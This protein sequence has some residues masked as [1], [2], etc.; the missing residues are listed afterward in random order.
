MKSNIFIKI[1]LLLATLSIL[2]ACDDFLDRE[3]SN[4]SSHGFYKSEAAVED[5]ASGVYNRLMFNIGFNIPFNISF[6]HWT[7]MAVE[8][9]E[10]TTIGAGGGLTPDN[11][12]ISSWWGG[13]YAIIG[14]ANAVLSGAEP[15]LDQLQSEGKSMQYLAEIRV[16]RA[17]AYYNLISLWGAVPFFT[18][19]VTTA[20]YNPERT[21]PG[22]I[23]DFI[24][25][26]LNTIA[27]EMPWIAEQRGRVDRSVAYGLVARAAL[28]GGSLDYNG[29][30]KEYFKIAAEAAKKVIGQ[31]SLAKNF[32]DLFNKTG[33]AKSDVRNEALFELMY[34]DQGTKRTHM[35]GFGQ[36]SRVYGQTGRHPSQILADTYEMANGKRIDEAGSGYDPKKPG[37]NRD[38]RFKATLWMHGDTIVGNKSGTDA[39]RIKFIADVYN[40]NTLFYDYIKDTWY[41][42]TNTDINSAAAWTSFANA[43]VGYMWRKYSNE[44]VENI[45][46]QT[47]NSILMRYAEVLLTYAEAKIELNELD[48]SVYD[49]INQVR[50]RSGMPNVSADRQGNQD[51]MRQLVRRER[52][53]ELALEGLF[54]VDM[55]RWK[56]GDIMNAEPSYGYPKAEK[57]ANGNVLKEGYDIATP[58]MIPNFKKSD[59]HNLNDIPTYEAYKSKLHVRDRDRFWN[60]KFELFPI[61]QV[62]IDKAP[63]LGQN[64]GY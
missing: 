61:P 58:D 29:K 24:I 32:D 30:G 46:A 45:S 41:E 59:L 22:V 4:P 13:L 3:P 18:K 37:E 50:N 27:E 26:D 2:P 38:P 11:T 14:R 47:C 43:G 42:A 54:L 48:Q 17:Y 60:E 19:P 1:L 63:N 8:R 25:E 56:I 64:K 57:D 12:N 20:E 10:N 34:S 40:P 9:A 55:R 52:K 6:D 33:Q 23:L 7:P 35:I 28:L 53:V 39:G 36:V 49:A 16:L 15:Y 5:G 51:K 62:E 21:E 31:R 44:V